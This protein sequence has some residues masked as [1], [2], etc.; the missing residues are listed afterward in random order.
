[1][2]IVNKKKKSKKNPLIKGLMNKI[3]GKGT[4]FRMDA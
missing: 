1:L 3:T 2:N 4:Q